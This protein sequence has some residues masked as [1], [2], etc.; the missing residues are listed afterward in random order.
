MLEEWFRLDFSLQG[1]EGCVYKY[2]LQNWL[3]N[4]DGYASEWKPFW[5]YFSLLEEF[6]NLG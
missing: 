5:F 1:E 6:L 3:E 4:T 2:I